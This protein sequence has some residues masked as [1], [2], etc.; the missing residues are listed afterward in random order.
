MNGII[1]P[2]VDNFSWADSIESSV[3]NMIPSTT[4]ELCL[5][6]GK[7]QASAREISILRPEV[8]SFPRRMAFSDWKLRMSLSQIVFNL[9]ARR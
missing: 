2:E 6:S 9:T 7:F 5:L 1:R 8:E 4:V 3:W